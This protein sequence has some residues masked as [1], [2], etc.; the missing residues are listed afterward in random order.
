MATIHRYLTDHPGQMTRILNLNERFIF[1]QLSPPQSGDIIPTGSL[2]YPLTTGRSV[3]MDA[4]YY[5]PGI[6]G[7]LTGR[8]PHFAKDGKV[9]WQ[10]FSRLVTHQDSGAAIKG[11]HRLDLYMGSGQGAGQAAGIMKERGSFAILTP[12]L[13]LR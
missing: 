13:S 4:G 8:L 3:A 9:S 1:F 6:L 10:P 12:N 2:G 5:P 7:I 11:P